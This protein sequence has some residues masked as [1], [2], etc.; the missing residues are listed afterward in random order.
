M[1]WI[2][3]RKS[4]E[5]DEPHEFV[6]FVSFFAQYAAG[7]ETG[8]DIGADSE[9]RKEIW[10]LKNET[11]FRTRL[12]DWVRA[13]QKFA[14]MSRNRVDLPQPLGPMSETNSPG[15]IDSEILL[16][17][18]R[19][20]SG[21]SGAPKAFADLLNAKRGRFVLSQG[22]RLI[23]PFCQTSK[24]SRILNKSVIRVEKKPAMMMR[25]AKTLPYS[26]QPCA[27]L[28]CQPRPDLTPT[29]SATT[30]VRKEAPRPMSKPM[31]IF[32]TA[33]GIATRKMR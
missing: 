9:P 1:M 16:R 8:L 12:V 23:I 2:G 21:W 30:R 27:Q 32:G 31:K 17:A 5:S 25:A 33:A 18:C 6:H 26:A 7:N 22:Y 3:I 15:A 28:T 14:A 29:D 24:R 19:R 13:N 10:I 20:V 11:A 4:L